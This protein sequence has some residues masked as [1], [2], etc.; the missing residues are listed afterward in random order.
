[1]TME[2]SVKI[3]GGAPKVPLRELIVECD[4]RNNNG[5]FTLHH[6]RGI[7][8]EKRFI[9]T[10]ANMDGVS[11]TPYKIVEPGWISFV[12]VTSRNGGKISLA[13]NDSN[14]PYI[15]SSSYVVIRV[16]D[17]KRLDSNYLFLMLQRGEFDRLARF[18]SW[19]SARETYSYDD[20]S[21]YEIPLPS[22]EVQREYVAAY[23]SLQHLAEQN[24]ALAQPL[25][26]ACSS[27]LSDLKIKYPS[28]SL[29]DYIEYCDERNGNKFGL[30]NLRGVSIEKIFIQTKAAMDGVSLKS[31]KLIKPNDFCYVPV[32]SR[33]GDK[34]TLALNGGNETYICS[35]AYEVFR[36]KSEH[37]IL[38][39]FL[40]LF[41]KRAEFDRLARYNSWGS[42]RETFAF[43]DL[44]RVKIPL[45]PIEVQRSI[46]ALYHCAEEA[47]AIAR[48]ALE[49]L[50][51]LAPA[52]V[53]RA[54]NTPVEV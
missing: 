46:V 11:L 31:Y 3:F 8:I 19:G 54:A 7:S 39:A 49:Q 17:R 25:Q 16:S 24:E 13:F 52:M 43:S 33:N 42:A 47:R 2:M 44:M 18:N 38:P 51:I 23:K 10:K 21:R 27:F 48:E 6:L 5:I 35:S 22:I 12:T 15:V 53:Q 37:L 40:F 45:P 30:K 36:V 50:K 1:M 28:Q 29:G 34:I 20:L 26:K 41:F 4:E 14:E 32:T 9:E